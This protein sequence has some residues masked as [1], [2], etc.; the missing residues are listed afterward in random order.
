[1]A[2][3]APVESNEAEWSCDKCTFVNSVDDLTCTMCFQVR[4]STRALPYTWQWL[5]QVDWITYDAPC[6][7]QIEAAYQSGA[8]SVALTKGFCAA[9]KGEYTIHFGRKPVPGAKPVRRRVSAPRAGDAAGENEGEGE[10]MS[11]APAAAGS[12]APAT[13]PAFTQR[14][15][16]SGMVRKVRRL[17]ND[18]DALF[19]VLKPSCVAQGERC[20]ICAEE[21]L[22]PDEEDV[23]GA[24]DAQQEPGASAPAVSQSAAAPSSGAAP[25]SSAEGAA[26][27]TCLELHPSDEWPESAQAA[28]KLSNC[29]PGHLFH[30]DC[31]AAWVKLKDKCPYCAVKI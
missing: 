28:V 24:V 15:N 23:Q 4:S 27:R 5:A 3:E 1:M 26:A 18:D 13:V 11:D 8:A 17:A 6:N 2:S 21:W 22:P 25:D 29:A 31:I 19:V 16:H 12:V 20:S 10:G 30:R 9:R 14:N 7:E